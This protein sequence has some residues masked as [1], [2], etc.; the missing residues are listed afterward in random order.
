[1]ITS[2]TSNQNLKTWNQSTY[3]E[4]SGV[5][6]LVN[7]FYNTVLSYIDFSFDG[8]DTVGLITTNI[9]AIVNLTSN[10]F[11]FKYKRLDTQ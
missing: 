2:I 1:M 11:L 8:I 6:N 10:T 7:T 3:V 5:K 4:L 9:I